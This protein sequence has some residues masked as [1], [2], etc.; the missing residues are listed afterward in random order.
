MDFELSLGLLYNPVTGSLDFCDFLFPLTE[1]SVGETQS[2][3]LLTFSDLS[4]L[5]VEWSR[6]LRSDDGPS[7]SSFLTESF[8]EPARDVKLVSTHSLFP[9]H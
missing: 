6:A 2:W 4:A 1:C 5:G 7:L 3:F 9:I 8:A